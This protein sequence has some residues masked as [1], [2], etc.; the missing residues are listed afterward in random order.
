MAAVGACEGAFWTASVRIGGAR[1]GTAAAILNTG[2]N[3]VGLLAPVVT[4]ALAVHFGWNAGLVLASAVCIAG[5]ALWW[6][7]DAG[8][9]ANLSSL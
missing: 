2:G 3:G 6:W 9:N 4:P 7:I 5:A 8:D 1:G